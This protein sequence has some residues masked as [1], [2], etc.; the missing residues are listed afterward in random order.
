MHYIG[1]SKISPLYSKGSIIYPQIRFPQRYNDVIGETAH[2]YETE[3]GGKRASFIEIGED[4]RKETF[5]LKADVLKPDFEVLKPYNETISESR[6]SALE[7]NIE[8]IKQ[9]LSQNINVFK[10]ESTERAENKTPESGF[11]P[12]SEP[13]QSLTGTS[14]PSATQPRRVSP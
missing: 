10:D 11:E 2:I 8:D 7:S 12:E 6:L 13:R 4:E 5:E 9:L 3:Y 1:K 14:R